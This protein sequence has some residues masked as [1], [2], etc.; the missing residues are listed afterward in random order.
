[1]ERNSPLS[2]YMSLNKYSFVKKIL[3]TIPKEKECDSLTKNK[4][5]CDSSTNFKGM[6]CHLL[7]NSQVTHQLVAVK[8]RVNPQLDLY[9]SN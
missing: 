7:D 9:M 6:N 5:K 1:M 4:I 3:S 8:L 2:L